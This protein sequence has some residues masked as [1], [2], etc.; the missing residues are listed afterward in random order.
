MVDQSGWEMYLQSALVLFG[1]L[2]LVLGTLQQVLG[3]QY[4]HWDV[5][6]EDKMEEM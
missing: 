1:L 4:C 6:A 2:L 5:P 3:A